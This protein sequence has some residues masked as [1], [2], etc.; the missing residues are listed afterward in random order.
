MAPCGGPVW[1]SIMLESC[2]LSL[3]SQQTR[4]PPLWCYID[5]YV[6]RFREALTFS[7]VRAMSDRQTCQHMSAC[8]RD[9]YSY[10]LGH[11]GMLMLSLSSVTL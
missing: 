6:F 7:H 1:R 8:H 4:L 10:K 2:N 5:S 3:W 11:A 9:F